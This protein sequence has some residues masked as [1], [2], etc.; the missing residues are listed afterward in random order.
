M[1]GQPQFQGTPAG[2]VHKEGGAVTLSAPISVHL[3]HPD[4][5]TQRAFPLQ[6]CTPPCHAGQGKRWWKGSGPDDVLSLAPCD[7]GQIPAPPPPPQAW[8]PFGKKVALLR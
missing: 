3:N 8:L 2:T 5:D 7:L 4:L 6:V 1:H